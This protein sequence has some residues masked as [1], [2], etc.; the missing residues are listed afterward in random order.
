MKR[1][2]DLSYIL[3]PNQE[4]L[5]KFTIIMKLL[6]IFLLLVLFC[7]V[8]SCEGPPKRQRYRNMGPKEYCLFTNEKL[9]KACNYL[10]PI[11]KSFANSCVK[12]EHQ[13]DFNIFQVCDVYDYCVKNWVYVNDPL[14]CEYVA[15]ASKTIGNKL[16]GDCDDFA[17]LMAASMMAI[18][19][20]CRIVT[21]WG[22]AGGH[23]YAELNISG[24]NVHD[25][26]QLIKMRYNLDSVE[27]ISHDDNGGMW[28]NLDWHLHPG[29]PY[30]PS[31][32][33]HIYVF[34]IK[35]NRWLKYE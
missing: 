30:F 9:A 6:R 33:K 7:F 10:S 24:F 25:I 34:H 11:T 1:I 29:Q 5:T 28:L 16:K 15:Q 13:G 4:I 31:E 20:N 18:G 21:A 27:G 19:G 22:E 32:K 8:S 26:K 3:F 2:K 17:I 23:A 35:T 14:G 12:K